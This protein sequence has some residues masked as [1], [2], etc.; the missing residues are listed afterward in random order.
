MQEQEERTFVHGVLAGLGP[1]YEVSRSQILSGGTLPSFSDLHG[2][3]FP[4]CKDGESRMMN[5]IDTAALVSDVS[6]GKR[7]NSVTTEGTRNSSRTWYHCGAEGHVKKNCWKLH[8]RSPQT[9]GQPPRCVANMIIQDGIL[10]TPSTVTILVY[11]YAW[12]QQL[13]LTASSATTQ[14]YIGNPVA[15]LSTSSRNWVIDSSGATDH[16]TGSW[17]EAGYW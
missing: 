9:S 7:T 12:P 6:H 17:D 10:P 4:V 15:C 14:V 1:Q 16:M 11:E 8:G 13:S 2:R 3:L 5:S